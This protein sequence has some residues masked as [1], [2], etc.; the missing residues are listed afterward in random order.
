MLLAGLMLAAAPAAASAA[1]WSGPFSLQG[2]AVPWF[3]ADNLSCP[4]DNACVMAGGDTMWPVGG[5]HGHDGTLEAF[6][7]LDPGAPAPK[8]VVPSK[9]GNDEKDLIFPVMCASSSGCLIP[10][11]DGAPA[12]LRFSPTSPITTTP[13]PVSASGQWS[14]PTATQCTTFALVGST[15]T[16][17]AVT[18]DP[19]TG[20][21][22][23]V[24]PMPSNTIGGPLSCPTATQCTAVGGTM[25][26][27]STV[28]NEVT[29]NPLQTTEPTPQSLNLPASYLAG[30]QCPSVSQCTQLGNA[31]LEITFDPANAAAA[32]TQKI[33][34]GSLLAS[35]T[36]F[37]TTECYGTSGGNVVF[38]NPNSPGTVNTTHVA[39]G[40]ARAA[41]FSASECVATDGSRAWVMLP[42][43]TVKSGHSKLGKLTDKRDTVKVPLRCTG[44]RGLVCHDSLSLSAEIN[45][46]YG[47]GTLATGHID[48]A[49]GSSRT[50]TLKLDK[51][52]VDY[53]AKKH[54]VPSTLG[55]ADPG[56]AGTAASAKLTLS[57]K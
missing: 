2:P 41:C 39:S 52:G 34:S 23:N 31:G 6:A 42:A 21:T 26:D 55:V 30:L 10:E 25:S 13:V 8:I 43:G 12:L 18:L 22:L 51:F 19:Q 9:G 45:T 32:T 47:D 27:G 40:V 33:G 3:Q 14:C 16:P 49:A 15:H 24:S 11:P 57:S 36:C 48:L 20:V 17:E 54:R 7:P 38:F 53:L 35:F 50:V 37:S 44:S 4:S 56:I 29:F 1:T 5:V 46:Y 28:W